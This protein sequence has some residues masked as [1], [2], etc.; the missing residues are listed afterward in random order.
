M[1]DGTIRILIADDHVFYREGVKSMLQSGGGPVVVV[2]E[3]ATGEEAIAQ[4]AALRPDVILMDLRMPGL[5]GIEATRRVVAHLPE[6]AVL[7]LTMFDDDSVFAAMRAGARGY[8]LKDATLGDLVRAVTAAHH[9]EAI[10]SPAIAARLVRYFSREHQ[11]PG[12]DLFPDLTGREREILQL[13]VRGSSNSDIAADLRLTSKTVRN[14]VS[15]ILT[16]LQVH[17]RSQAIVKARDAG[18]PATGAS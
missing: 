12:A 7:I 15:N 8:L 11:S 13:L 17:D 16:K 2:G 9:G 1:S 10:F 5:T 3:A 18:F 14:Y 4:A 6:V